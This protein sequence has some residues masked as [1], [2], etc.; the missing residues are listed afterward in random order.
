MYNRNGE[1][2]KN[3]VWDW[4]NKYMMSFSDWFIIKEDCDSVVEEVGFIFV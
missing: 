2:K 3:W 4:M 1:I